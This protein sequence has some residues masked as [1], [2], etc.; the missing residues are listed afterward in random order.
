MAG[1]YQTITTSGVYH[2]LECRR[3]CVLP[4][5]GRYQDMRLAGDKIDNDNPAM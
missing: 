4:W 5:Q 3:Y 2:T 1:C